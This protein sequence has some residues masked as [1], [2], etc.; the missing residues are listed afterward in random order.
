MDEPSQSNHHGGH[1][2]AVLLRSM[3][4]WNG[5][6]GTSSHLVGLRT[7]PRSK[8]DCSDFA[9]VL[10]LERMSRAELV[11]TTEELLSISRI[12][13]DEPNGETCLHLTRVIRFRATPPTVTFLEV[14]NKIRELKVANRKEIRSKHQIISKKRGT[15]V[16]TALAGMTEE[17]LSISRIHGGE[18]NGETCLHLTRAIRFRATPPT[19]TF[20]EVRKK[21]RELNVANR[22]EVRSKHQIISKKRETNVSTSLAVSIHGGISHT[23]EMWNEILKKGPSPTKNQ[24]G[25]LRLEV[26]TLSQQSK[27]RTEA[28]YQK[29]KDCKKKVNALLQLRVSY[30]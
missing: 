10:R 21:I 24:G 26:Q 13:G 3:C 17:L 19:V 27:E 25:L 9:G 5:G 12:H 15:N 18:P 11:G 20:L 4:R 23:R 30:K 6:V 22:K 16:S 28:R 2:F 8:L 7:L 29:S 14:R 1:F